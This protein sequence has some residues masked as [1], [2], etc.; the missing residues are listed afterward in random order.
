[1]EI[2]LFALDDGKRWDAPVPLDAVR[3]AV[4]AA[5]PL[6]GRSAVTFEP[7]G[8]VELSSAPAVDVATAVAILGRD[9]A[10]LRSALR[11][12]RIELV[13]QGTDPVRP[14][15]RVVDAPRYRAME[16]YFDRA[17]THGRLM[18]C[19]TAA[20]QVNVGLGPETARVRRWELAHAVGPAL[21]SAFA[22]SPVLA[23]RTTGCKS[24]RLA[25]WLSID[26]TRTAPPDGDYAAFALAA[27][28]MLMRVD[29]DTFVPVGAPLPFAQ[30]I[31]SGHEL[32]HPTADDLDYHLTTLFPPVRPRGWLEVRYLDALPD[33]WWQ[34]A[35]AVLVALLDDEEA[36]DAASRAVAGT[37]G[38]WWEAAR[39]GL[40]HPALSRAATGCFTAALAA[41]ERAPALGGPP[42]AADV[43]SFSERFL[44]RGRCPGDELVRAAG[45]AWAER[46]DQRPPADVSFGDRP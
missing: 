20:L 26:S 40:T 41:V 28:V 42:M 6:P 45:G 16:A 7:G 18:M 23:G 39:H 44:E 21:V 5:G 36:G 33:P 12:R 37:E 2:E 24:A 11:R 34:V 27:H 38:L 46:I 35:T 17:G 14:P 15:R 9:L 43:A 13:A 30:W 29:G 10:A 31:E 4:E 25:T 3:R 22:N 19:S 8:Q 32:G 1:V